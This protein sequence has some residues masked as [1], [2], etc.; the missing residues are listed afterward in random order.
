MGESQAAAE[1]PWWKSSVFYEIYM[2]SFCDGNGDG[3]GDF[4]GLTSKLDYLRDLGIGGIWLT[5]FYPSPRVDNGYDISDYYGVDP[6]FGTLA[7]FDRFVQEA[8]RRGI[9]VIADLVLNHTSAEHSWFIES[10]SSRTSPKRDWYI[11]KDAVDGGT[12]NNWESFF[13]GSAWEWDEATGQYYYH[14]FAR[15]QVDLNWANPEVREA[16]KEVMSFWLGR[17]IDGFRLDVINFLK[18]SG[19]FQGNPV[20]AAGGQDHRFDQNQEGILEAIRDICEF[21][22]SQNKEVFMVGEVGSEDMEVLRR[23]SGGELLDVVFNFNLGSCKELI[24]KKLF[25]ELVR[26]EEHHRPE[27]MPTLFF[28]SHDMPR[29]YTRFS[30]GKDSM[31]ICTAKLMAALMLT[32]KGVPFIYYGD[33]IGMRDFVPED[34]GQMRDIQGLTAYRMAVESGMPEDDAL[35]AAISRSRDHSRTPMQWDASRYAGFSQHESWIP[36]GP[37]FREVHVQKQWGDAQSLLE[38]YRSLIR[39]RGRHKALQTGKYNFLR[40]IGECVWYGRQSEEEE[41]WVAL[42]FG[43]H[44]CDLSE[45]GADPGSYR[46]LLTSGGESGKIERD[47]MVAGPYEASVWV[48][49]H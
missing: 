46:L 40:L 14:A 23:Y 30:S 41:M 42:N 25:A 3:T 15:E 35:A 4:Q 33:E 11:W 20:T 18:V 9:R 21:A 31:D 48:V 7:D 32:A 45:M 29:H 34:I 5:P 27:Q 19:Q 43:K 22:R 38:F 6:V 44:A 37:S 8:H 12:P 47:S 13:G 36:F 2:P 1:T 17:G 26:M 28:S 39:L 10:R 16:M 49:E 24:V